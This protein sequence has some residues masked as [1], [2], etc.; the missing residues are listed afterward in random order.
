MR[1]RVLL[2]LLVS[3]ARPVAG[4]SA[5]A[6]DDIVDGALH[7]IPARYTAM[8]S[9]FGKD[10]GIAYRYGP[11]AISSGSAN[12]GP[13]LHKRTDNKLTAPAPDYP[14]W[15]QV[16]QPSREPGSYSSN[17]GSIAFVADDPAQRV[18]VADI[19][20][21]NYMHGVFAQSP[22]LSWT[23]A[24]APGG[25]IGS[26]TVMD[27]RAQ[28]LVRGDP[29][30][31][32]RCTGKPG[33]CAEGLVAFQNGV[34]GT[35][36]SN[37]AHNRA[38]VK[39]PANKVPTGIAMT[40][41][42]EFALVTVWD[43]QA[44]KG[45]VAVIALAGLCDGCDPQDPTRW[46]N[47]WEEWMGVYPGLP[48]MGDIAFMKIL[49]YV[50]LPGMAAPTEI[51]V[52]TGMDQ[53]RSLYQGG[54]TAG[55]FVGRANS[56]LTSN[57][58][59]FARGGAQEYNYAKGGVA[60]VISKS[61]QKAAFIDLKPLFSYFNGV[62]FSPNVSQTTRFGQAANQWPFTFDVQ[63]AQKPTVLKTV[64]LGARPTAVKTTIYG[65]TP[66]AWI[67]T[68]D[69]TLHIF[70][71]DG[72]APGDG[73]KKGASPSVSNIAEVGRVTGIGR[74]PT[75]LATSKGEPSDISGEPNNMQ[76]IVAS[77]GDNRISWVRFAP[78]GNSGKIVRTIRHQEMKD[79]IAVEDADNF[80]NTGFV[81]SA[82]DYAG[83]AVRNYR[84]GPVIFSD[85][86]ACPGPKG[87]PINGTVA[88]YG[89]AMALPG[90]PFQMNSANVP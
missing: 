33:F 80:S 85:G 19:Q 77:R 30:A 47:Y 38:T 26:V 89:G 21:S 29:V 74:N 23:R 55:Q 61:E 76:V 53:F 5:P 10:A 73:W 14:F 15:W 71:L 9:Q 59:N 83:K 11:D 41:N 34:I 39:L 6:P 70:S 3:L 42:S 24:T 2:L 1:M 79:L 86:G 17:Q 16:G 18:G 64:S 4:A 50:D 90:K 43:T 52:T 27:Y 12:T 22:Q 69:G 84:Y 25:G 20:V 57:W 13:A 60:V 44:L 48:N 46:Y 78:N 62:Y 81:L 63:D 40:N 31:V 8:A 45:Q 72:F 88:E 82:L 75:A 56:P 66:R 49:G 37:T 36:G 32:G 65:P 67:A 68:Q 87:C 58:R 28:G 35:I 51:A 54:S 7:I